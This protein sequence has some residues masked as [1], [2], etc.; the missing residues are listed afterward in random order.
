MDELAVYNI[1]NTINLEDDEELK[2]IFSKITEHVIN[3]DFYYRKPYKPIRDPNITEDLT[4]KNLRRS[5][6]LQSNFNDCNLTGVGFTDSIFNEVFFNNA[7]VNGAN[8]ESSYFFNCGFKSKEPYNYLT[9]SKSLF[10]NTSFKEISFN[11]CRLSDVTF[12]DTYI[13]NCK[14]DNTSFDSTVFNNTTLDHVQF[15]NLNLEYTQFNNVHMYDTALPF[16]T[17]PFIINGISYLKTTDDNVYIKSAKYEKISKQDYIALIP[18]LILYYKKAKNYFPL[19][20]I[21]LSENKADEAFSCILSG[22]S[23]SILLNNYRQLKNYCILSSSSNAFDIHKKKEILNHITNE[24]KVYLNSNFKFY[25]PLS[26]HFYE[27]SN[28]LLNNNSTTLIISFNTNINNNDYTNLLEFYKTIDELVNVV[29]IKSNYS[30]KYSYNS[31]AE[32]MAVISNLDTSVLVALI[33]AFTTLFIAGIKGISQ[34]PEVI[35]KFA[36]VR[37]NIKASRKRIE[38]KELDIEIKKLELLKLQQEVDKTITGSELACFDNLID[39]I[40]PILQSCDSLK[41]AGVTINDINYN[42]LNLNIESLTDYTNNI[43]FH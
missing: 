37:D 20:N 41:K 3:K 30:I 29:G 25:Y 16:P 1:E 27:L 34:L 21:F 40:Q 24:L 17:I 33:T 43:L 32:I 35:E 26:Q 39:G 31:Q 18:D 4:N 28:I 13:Q 42:S 2:P 36:T 22:I 12:N 5:Y 23:Q 38:E 6:Y 8:F 9:L 19:A 10:I 7:R 15:S 14:F 11:Q